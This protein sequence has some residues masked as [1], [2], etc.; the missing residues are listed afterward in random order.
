MNIRRGL[1]WIATAGLGAGVMYFMDPKMGRRRR[2][3]IR[4]QFTNATRKV[5]R[6]IQGST[7]DAKKRVY[8]LYREALRRVS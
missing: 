3:M 8:G 4:D 7:N 1:V 5:N 6:A 2:S